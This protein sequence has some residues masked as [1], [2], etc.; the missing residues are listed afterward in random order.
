MTEERKSCGNPD[1]EVEVISYFEETDP[2]LKRMISDPKRYS[3]HVL[4][5]HNYRLEPAE[6]YAG[7]RRRIDEFIDFCQ[8]GAFKIY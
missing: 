8:M 6:F 3:G 2:W 7:Q 1:I 5:M 4:H